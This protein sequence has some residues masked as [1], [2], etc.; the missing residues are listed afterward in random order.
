MARASPFF[1]R[2]VIPALAGASLALALPPFDFL[3]VVFAAF[4]ALVWC[5]DRAAGSVRPVRAS[6]LVGWAFGFGYFL[7]GLW[8]IGQAFLVEAE[9]FA[10]LMPFAVVALPAGLALFFALA[11]GA[12]GALWPQRGGTAWPWRI[13]LLAALMTTAEWLRATVLTGFPWNG[14][15]MTVQPV[16]FLMQSA[17]WLGP[18]GV[19]FLGVAVAAAPVLAFARRD[20]SWT[21]A[22]VV[23][24]CLAGL[25]AGAG[26]LRMPSDG[27]PVSAAAGPVVRLVQPGIDQRDKWRAGRE[28][29]ILLRHLLPTGEPLAAGGTGRAFDLAVWPESAFPFLVQERPERLAAIAATLLPGQ[30]LATGAMR[31][32][33]RTSDLANAILLMDAEAAT[34][35]HYDKVRLVPFGEYLPLTGLLSAVGLRKLVPGSGFLPGPERGLLPVA[36]VGRA[37]PLICYEVIFP[38]PPPASGPGRPDFVLTVTNDAWFGMTPGPH[39]HARMAQLRGVEWGLPVVRAANTGI[40]FVSDRWGRMAARI[41][42]GRSGFA[43]ATLPPESAPTIHARTW[44]WPALVLVLLGL[45][46]PT[47][48]RR[49]DTMW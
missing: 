43:D 4:P 5:L 6:A 36:G 34:V 28:E 11:G 18:H 30:Q 13:F 22:L 48:L 27:G 29:T 21:A 14:L 38:D 49:V 31:R 16:P 46:V 47:S 9:E 39:Q 15:G 26:A 8:W 33:G 10:A 42:L 44:H 2:L 45:I 24:L 7:A 12:A 20:R 41:E 32:V 3:P 40:S 17:A 1:V 37:W 35:R 25:H 19:T 23:V